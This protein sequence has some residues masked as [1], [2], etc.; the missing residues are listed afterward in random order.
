MKELDLILSDGTYISERLPGVSLLS[1]KPESA[2]FERNT[3][4]THPLRNGILMPRKGNKGRYV[5]RKVV[6]KL[7]INARNSQHFHLIRDDLSRLFTSEDPFYI[8]YTYQPNKRWLVTG[9]DGF[10]LEQDSNK[11]WKEQDITLTDIQGLAESLYD[12]SVP[13]KIGKWSLGMNMGKVEN[14]V[15]S[16]KNTNRFEVYN[17][18]DV[19]VSPIDHKYDVEMCFEGKDIEILNETTGKSYTLVG[20]QS[21]ENKLNLRKHYTVNGSTIVTT[22]GACFPPLAPGKNKFKIINAT[23]S[24]IKFLTHFYYK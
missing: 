13:F 14:P 22:K 23:Y 24:E 18:G 6:V 19:E 2:R 4:N 15:Y 12:T 16:F 3:S 9:D 11:T 8:G 10:S 1:F 21:K 7:L 17:L 20:S 5:E